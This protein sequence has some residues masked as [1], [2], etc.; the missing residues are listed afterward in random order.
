MDKKCFLLHEPVLK[1]TGENNGFP[2]LKEINRIGMGEWR[3]QG[4]EILI[5]AM[6]FIY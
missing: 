4:S 3:H 1:L 5:K 6:K 2:V